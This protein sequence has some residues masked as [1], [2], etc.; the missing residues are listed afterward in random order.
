MSLLNFGSNEGYTIE[1]P[2]NDPTPRTVI[3]QS[4]ISDK[5]L[6]LEDRKIASKLSIQKSRD[7]GTLQETLIAAPRA[8]GGYIGVFKT[9]LISAVVIFLFV[10]GFSAVGALLDFM[11][12][13]WWLGLIGLIILVWSRRR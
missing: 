9:I 1:Y 8:I 5:E 6:K 3:N 13:Y 4:D 7:K 12:W 2:T 11:D 10:G